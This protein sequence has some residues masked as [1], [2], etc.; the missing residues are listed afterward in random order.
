M[1]S[2]DPERGCGLAI[3]GGAVVL[4]VVAIVAAFAIRAGLV[5]LT[6][7]LAL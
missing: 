5:S 4:L 2:A 1:S 6:G 7:A 3:V